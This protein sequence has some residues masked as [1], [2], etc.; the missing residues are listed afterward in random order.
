MEPE[1]CRGHL[2]NLLADEAALLRQLEKQLSLEHEL[3]VHNDVDGLDAAGAARQNT[4]TSLLRVDEDRRALCRM[5]GHGADAPG[6]AAMLRWCDPAG[7]LATAQ[8]E[9]TTRA[10]Q[11]RAQNDRNGA[12]VS[13]RL[14]RVA[15]MLGMLDPA[16]A[17]SSVY[18]AG[19][20]RPA[21]EHAGRLL[22]TRA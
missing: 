10:I 1:A 17:K 4:V 13:A 3:L 8:S 7:T 20:T 15:G 19:G 5:L 2:A 22:A 6:L 18:G 11:C 14:S 12:L 16:P 21:G 9:V